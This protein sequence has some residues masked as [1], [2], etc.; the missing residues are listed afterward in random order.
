MGLRQSGPVAM[1]LWLFDDDADFAKGNAF[2]RAA[3]AAGAYLHPRH[4]MFLNAAHTMADMD[5][6]LEAAGA[7]FA[8]LSAA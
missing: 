1:P 5:A 4:N 8:A 2:C 6:V 3:L 7:G